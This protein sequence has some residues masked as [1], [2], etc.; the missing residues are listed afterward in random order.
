MDEA[1]FAAE[2]EAADV[3]EAE[4]STRKKDEEEAK[5]KAAEKAAQRFG[6][7]PQTPE[8]A[9]EAARE[10]ARRPRRLGVRPDGR[11]APVRRTG[12][13]RREGKLTISEALT[14]RW[15]NPKN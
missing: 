1:R 10:A 5:R 2:R 9:E 3:R 14:D 13:R 12:E 4:E 15:A 7:A 6:D 11:R 8:A